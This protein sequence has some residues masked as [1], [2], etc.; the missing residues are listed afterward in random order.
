MIIIITPEKNI[1]NETGIINGLFREELDLLHLRKPFMS[2]DALADFIRNIDS[3]FHHRLVLCSHY[4][5]AEPFGISRLHFREAD[6]KNNCQNPFTGKIISTSV[7]DIETFNGLDK[8]WAYAFVSPVFPS[9]SKKGYGEHSTVLSEVKKR[10]NPDVQ[11][12]ALGGINQYNIQD[13]FENGADGAAL[14]GAIWEN[15]E[16]LPVFRACMQ[17]IREMRNTST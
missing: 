5:L 16:P 6:R 14:L 9:I 10:S 17:A 2:R 12:V 7:H 4:E 3:E 15:Q 13:I 1:N 8:S 11:L